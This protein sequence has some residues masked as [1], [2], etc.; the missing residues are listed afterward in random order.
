MFCAL[1][2]FYIKSSF[3]EEV[4][5]E[6]LLM[7][8]YRRQ[9]FSLVFTD[10][11]ICVFSCE[12]IKNLVSRD[13]LILELDTSTFQLFARPQIY[14]KKQK[15]LF[16]PHRR[17]PTIEN[18]SCLFSPFVFINSPILHKWSEKVNVTSNST[19]EILIKYLLGEWG[20]QFLK[21]C[22]LSSILDQGTMSVDECCRQEA[23][24]PQTTIRTIE[25]AL[26]LI[27]RGDHFT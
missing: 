2:T 9:V 27:L 24:L 17:R 15:E 23:S 3:Y 21:T 10:Y 20:L 11:F 16:H 8:W 22:E 1:S 12:W 14:R 25:K 13:L 7:W 19:E 5:S 6:S 26:I 4:R 18:S